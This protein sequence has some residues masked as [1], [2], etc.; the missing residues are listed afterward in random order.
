MMQCIYLAAQRGIR[1]VH[2]T[3]YERLI[4]FFIVIILYILPV[5]YILYVY[6]IFHILL[7]LWQTTRYMECV[8]VC[9]YVRPCVCARTLV[10][11][12]FFILIEHAPLP[13][14]NTTCCWYTNQILFQGMQWPASPDVGSHCIPF[15]I[16]YSVSYCL[17]SVCMYV[18]VYV[19]MCILIAD[20]IIRALF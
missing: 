14:G 4:V 18:C 16:M 7:S 6:N 15:A 19:C 20:F 11:V 1:V 5:L 13:W 3:V 17:K 10:C 8:Y 9:M 12:C 2:S